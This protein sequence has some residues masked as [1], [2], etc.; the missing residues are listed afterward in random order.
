M[1]L[2]S[3]PNHTAITLQ[4]W[5][6]QEMEDAGSGCYDGSILE[7]STDGGTTWTKLDNTVL[8]TDP[9]DGLISSTFNNP[10]SGEEAWCGDPQDWLRSVVD[11]DA[12]AGETV[13][14]RFRLGTDSS[15]D[16]P[17][18]DIDDVWVQSCVPEGTDDIFAD[19][20]ESGDASAWDGHTTP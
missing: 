12:Y 20:F 17:G 7:I 16:H 6:Y 18:W 15:V 2:P 5:N 3:G 4:F 13:Q 9:Y 19:G 1:V 14:F 10:L 11:L 8:Q